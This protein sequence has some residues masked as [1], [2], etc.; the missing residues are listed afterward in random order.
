MDFKETASLEKRIETSQRLLVRH[1]GSVPVILFSDTI[2][3]HRYKLI[4]AGDMS[5][6][7]FLIKVRSYCNLTQGETLFVLIKNATAP[8]NILIR[9]LYDKKRDPDG[10]LYVYV[11]KENVF[12]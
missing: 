6:S 11:T 12:G 4:V 9:D 1:P 10:F 3:F 5:L 8:G 2:Q 7:S